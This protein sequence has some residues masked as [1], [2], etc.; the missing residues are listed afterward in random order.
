MY[1][2]IAKSGKMRLRTKR[3]QYS[4]HFPH[5]TALPEVPITFH[6]IRSKTDSTS[7]VFHK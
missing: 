7:K 1:L 3:D 6:R 5:G 4:T 2:L